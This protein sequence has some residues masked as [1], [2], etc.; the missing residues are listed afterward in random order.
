M[1]S[2]SAPRTRNAE[3]VRARLKA[4]HADT[5]PLIEYYRGSGKLKV[6]DG[7]ADIGTVATEIRAALG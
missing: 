3:T 5:A 2:S 7:M 4:Y 1:R 6:V